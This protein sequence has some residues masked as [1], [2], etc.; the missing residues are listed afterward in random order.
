MYSC[1]ITSQKLILDSQ[2]FFENIRSYNNAFSLTSLGAEIDRSVLGQLGVYTF[3]IHGELFHLI[4]SLLPPPL[5]TPKFAQIYLYDN[6]NEQAHLRMSHF[7]EVQL[8]PR[9]IAALQQ[10]LH[11]WNPYAIELKH[12]RERLRE[13][14]GGVRLKLTTL[15][16]PTTNHRRHNRPTADEVA[17]IIPGSDG[18]IDTA[19]RDIIIE[20][21][22]GRLQRIQEIHSG[23]L[24]M[25]YPL[26]LPYG[27]QG[28]YPEMTSLSPYYSLY[29]HR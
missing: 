19:P 1:L 4:G 12:A 6:F 7:T 10:M 8:N 17:I 27:E 26:L 20:F 24:P 16:A 29:G 11:N 25:R 21:R 13:H 14:P 15:N 2:H 9:I 23:Y 5:N 28:W 3:R 22:D 18:T